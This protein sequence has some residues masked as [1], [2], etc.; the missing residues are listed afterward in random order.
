MTTLETNAASAGRGRRRSVQSDDIET[1]LK[2]RAARNAAGLSQNELAK[3]LGVTFQQVQKYEKGVNRVGTT[4][5]AI[6]AEATNKPVTY[7]FPTVGKVRRTDR[8]RARDEFMASKDGNELI[9]VM[10][11]L[12]K[13]RRMNVLA[14]ARGLVEG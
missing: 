4:R 12:P 14:L 2:I 10:M 5:I 3:L 7:F 1:G 11:L 8:D 6:I 9:N 13:P